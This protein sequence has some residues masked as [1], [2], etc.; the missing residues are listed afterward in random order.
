MLKDMMI[1]RLHKIQQSEVITRLCFIYKG[2]Q[3][4]VEDFT[5]FANERY[6]SQELLTS[7]ATGKP[8]TIRLKD[9]L[10]NF[11]IEKEFALN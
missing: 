9:E 2:K 10:N 8:L 7:L 1:D 4:F 5:Q 3:D 11:V 6:M